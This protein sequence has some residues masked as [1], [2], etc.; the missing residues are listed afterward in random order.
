MFK[1]TK[2]DGRLAEL[3]SDLATK[4][5]AH[6]LAVSNFTATRDKADT[7]ADRVA[8]A[9]LTG[10]LD[11]QNLETE[12]KSVERRC[13]AFAS[14]RNAVGGEIRE[15]EA[16]IVLEKTRGQREAAAQY[17]ESVADQIDAVVA[18]LRPGMAKLQ[19]SM[20]A[21]GFPD[22]LAFADLNLARIFPHNVALGCGAIASDDPKLWTSTIRAFAQEIRDGKR[23]FQLGETAMEIAQGRVASTTPSGRRSRPSASPAENGLITKWP[24]RLVWVRVGRRRVVRA[25][26]HRHFNQSGDGAI[27]YSAT[28]PSR[29]EV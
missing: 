3:E 23:S 17:L 7:L 21:V 26:D 14:A 25:C 5:Q 22:L 20:E 6:A 19:S 8:R 1:S 4:R 10:D 11:L 15:I 28:A 24:A 13:R 18:E 27:L 12:L 16:L 2:N 9:A 29:P